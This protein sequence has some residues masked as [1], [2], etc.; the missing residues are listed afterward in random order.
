MFNKYDKPIN[1][2]NKQHPAT[3]FAFHFKLKMVMMTEGEQRDRSC[4]YLLKHSCCCC[5][6]CLDYAALTP[7]NHQIRGLSNSYS[8]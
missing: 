2:A 8:N 5:C 3:P 4:D 6:C 1:R 7:I